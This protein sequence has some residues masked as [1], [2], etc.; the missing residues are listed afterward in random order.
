MF[1]WHA[2]AVFAAGVLAIPTVAAGQEPAPPPPQPLPQPAPAVGTAA[3][4][5]PAP[6][7]SPPASPATSS[8]PPPEWGNRTLAGHTFLFPALEPSSFVAT[9]VGIRQ[10]VYH[11][12]F[13]NVPLPFGGTQSLSLLGISDDI[14]LSFRITDWLGIGGVAQALGVLGSNGQSLLFAGGNVNA[15][16]SILPVLRIARIES[17]GTQVSFLARVGWLP[18]DALDLPSFLVAGS[19]AIASANV[20]GSPQA[21]AA[22]IANN[23]LQNGIQRTVLT[24]TDN[25]MLSGSFTAAQA[26]GP[27]FG[28]QAAVAFERSVF[29]V[30]SNLVPTGDVRVSDTRYD[31]PIDASLDWDGISLGVPLALQVEYEVNARI[32]STGPELLEGD[33]NVAQVIG[34]GA[35]YSG[36]QDLQLGLFGAYAWGLRPLA[37]IGGAPGSSDPSRAD[38]L[39]LVL[40]HIW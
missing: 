17:T 10:G 26:L 1:K 29:G 6:A 13:P 20:A 34:A 36:A 5:V 7:P 32:H 23:V 39:Q 9:Y 35:Y 38:Y 19:N 14:E 12:M 24:H 37:G 3:P 18:G 4:A 22:A 27:M 21:T 11:Q 15:G 25:F 31:I 28:L 30:T 2:P 16:G 40:R 33:S 8:P